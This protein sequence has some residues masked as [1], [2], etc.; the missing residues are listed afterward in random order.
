MASRALASAVILVSSIAASL[1]VSAGANAALSVVLVV[2]PAEHADRV[3]IEDVAEVR[4]WVSGYYVLHHRLPDS[5][6][7][8]GGANGVTIREAGGFLTDTATHTTMLYHKGVSTIYRLCV[9]FQKSGTYRDAFAQ[10]NHGP[11]SQC[12]TFDAT[13]QGSPRTPRPDGLWWNG[14]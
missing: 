8:A 9:T 2:P 10:W 1:L 4:D 12:F 5:L 14:C 6:E 11:G 7:E 3:R 13:V